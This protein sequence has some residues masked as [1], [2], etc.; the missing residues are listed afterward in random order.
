M[1]MPRDG[2]DSLL[3]NQKKLTKVGSKAS[4]NRNVLSHSYR[5]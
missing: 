3:E 2:N 5:G 4:Q 1:Q